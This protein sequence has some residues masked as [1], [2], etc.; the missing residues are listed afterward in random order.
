VTVDF[1]LGGDGWLRLSV[2]DEPVI[3]R[4]TSGLA[5]WRAPVCLSRGRHALALEYQ[6]RSGS[7]RLVLQA[8][9]PAEL[10][11]HGR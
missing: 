7:G 6:T 3:V 2:D 8:E 1:L 5:F 4:Q 9:A 10:R 11:R